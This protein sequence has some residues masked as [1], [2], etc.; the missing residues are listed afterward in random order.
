[1]V[2]KLDMEK[3]YDKVD[4]SLLHFILLHI[5]ILLNVSKWIMSCVNSTSFAVLI[6]G[7]PSIF[8][9]GTKGLRQG[10]PLSPYLFLLIIEGLSLKLRKAKEDKQ[11]SGVKVFGSIFIS[12]TLF[13]DDAIIFGRGIYAEW[14][15]IKGIIDVFC[16]ASGMS[17]S[18][19]KSCF[20][21][22][23]V[24]EG[25]I[26]LIEDLFLV[27]SRALEEGFT[28]LGFFLKPNAYIHSDWDCL[29]HKV[30]YQISKWSTN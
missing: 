6:N 26:H 4:R 8:F 16:N 30:H 23:G 12:H 20:S 22:F 19:T 11:I 21:H 7:S 29:T 14:I 10:C 15:I 2:L 1:M 25:V 5:N 27:N 13:V 17:F 24:E 18:T 28:Y 9:K 3:A